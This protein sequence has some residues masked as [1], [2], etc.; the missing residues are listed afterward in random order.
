[1]INR[2]Q[3]KL[4]CLDA[5]RISV[6]RIA[7]AQPGNAQLVFTIPGYV[8]IPNIRNAGASIYLQNVIRIVGVLIQNCRGI[9]EVTVSSSCEVGADNVMQVGAE[10]RA[11]A[12]GGVVIRGW[13]RVG[14]VGHFVSSWRA[15]RQE[16]A[17]AQGQQG[18]NRKSRQAKLHA[19]KFTGPARGKRPLASTRAE[20]ALFSKNGSL[21]LTVCRNPSL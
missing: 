13:W 10:R 14:R 20:S 3:F 21:D 19:E 15:A 8:G 6:V 2:S 1:M 18:E 9:T 7:C 5:R 12:A 11:R 4:V 17:G 16:L